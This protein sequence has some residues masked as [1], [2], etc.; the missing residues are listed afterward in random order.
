MAEINF[1]NKIFAIFPKK[2]QV[3]SKT[4]LYGHCPIKG[5]VNLAQS[6]F[7]G[8]GKSTMKARFEP[9]TSGFACQCLAH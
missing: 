3:P 4:F 9:V 1:E 5:G 8:A 7:F 6:G 2:C